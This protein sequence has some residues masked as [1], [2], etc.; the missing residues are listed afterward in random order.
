MTSYDNR[1]IEI[2]PATRTIMVVNV[3]DYHHIREK[4]HADPYSRHCEW[5]P[6]T[7][8]D[9]EGYRE[10]LIVN[11]PKQAE[12][13]RSYFTYNGLVHKGRA[14]IVRMKTVGTEIKGSELTED[15]VK[16]SVRFEAHD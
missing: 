12:K 3:N 6:L 16:A 8:A 9:Q 14:I 13:V 2:D 7:A 4:L 1:C 11:T 10:V 5:L 15:A